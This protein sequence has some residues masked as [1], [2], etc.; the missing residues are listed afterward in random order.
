MHITKA[1][2]NQV[3]EMCDVCHI[4]WHHMCNTRRFSSFGTQWTKNTFNPDNTQ[5]SVYYQLK[6]MQN[7]R[8][9]SMKLTKTNIEKW[10]NI[11]A[12]R[13]IIHQPNEACVCHLMRVL[14]SMISPSQIY[15][16]F[17]CLVNFALFF[18]KNI[19]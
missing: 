2:I 15:E 6:S 12:W 8:E 5:L 4:K 7:L 10:I 13:A 9:R 3:I 18:H 1:S 14:V 11:Q 19:V 17:F 16:S